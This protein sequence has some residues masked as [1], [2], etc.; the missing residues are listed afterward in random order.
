M[1]VEPTHPSGVTV[2]IVGIERGD[3]GRSCEEHDVCG[4]VVAEDT[5]L[6]LRKEQI[7]VDG[8]EETAIT[9][10]W[11]TDGIDCCQVGFLKRHMVKHDKGFSVR[12]LVFPTLRS[13]K[14]TTKIMVVHLGL[15]FQ[16]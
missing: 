13:G 6:R 1:A 7:L 15:S 14:C 3:R 8:Q 5:L 16:P 4:T 11:V 9:C 12:F 2:E 10:Y